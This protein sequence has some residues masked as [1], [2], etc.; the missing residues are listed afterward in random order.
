M[1]GIM[2]NSWLVGVL[3]VGVCVLCRS[4]VADELFRYNY[5]E[6][7]YGK[8]TDDAKGFS[9]KIDGS[10]YG[11]LGSYAVHELVA[12]TIQYTKLKTSFNGS[13]SGTP[14]SL[15]SNGNALTVGVTLHKMISDNTELG[16]DLAR[17]HISYDAY[18]MTVAGTPSTVPSSTDNTNDF[19]IRVRTAIVPEFRLLASAGRTTGGSN[20][21]STN[22]DI[23]AEY[24]LGKDFSLGVD[25]G[26]STSSTGSSTDYARGFSI[27][28]RYYY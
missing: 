10:D 13:F 9:P 3:V 18:T 1:G 23:G 22:Y 15:T 21:A 26:L 28:G 14:V 11:I 24:E 6:A 8:V 4:A 5:V 7:G 27:S 12:I 20:A 25:Y 16:L 19:G 17:D 2:R